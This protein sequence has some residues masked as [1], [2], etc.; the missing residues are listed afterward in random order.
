[1]SLQVQDFWVY[2]SSRDKDGK[3]T[4]TCKGDSGGPLVLWRNGGWELVGILKVVALVRL[5]N[6]IVV[7]FF[8]G[9][10]FDCS[11]NKSGGDGEW[12]NVA[13]QKRWILNQLSLGGNKGAILDDINCVLFFY[14]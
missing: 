2:T 4:D 10:G 12:S 6:K 9:E 13:F 11:T 7:I 14:F 5:C 1:M 3:I 8:Q